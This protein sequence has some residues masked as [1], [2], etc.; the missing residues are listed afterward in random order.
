MIQSFHSSAATFLAA[1]LL[2]FSFVFAADSEAQGS[3]SAGFCALTDEALLAELDGAWNLTQGPG[4]VNAG[5]MQIPSPPHPPVPVTFE[6]DP[7]RGVV[8][9]VAADLSD[10][11][12]MFASVPSIA[13]DLA[14]LAEEGAEPGPP[15]ECP[16]SVVP[17]LIGTN[18]Y[19]LVDDQYSGGH[20]VAHLC[21]AD[22]WRNPEPG[23]YYDSEDARAWFDRN[24]QRE[25]ADGELQMTLY[26]R[27][28]G[29]DAGAGTIF[30]SGEQDGY[31]AM[32][33]AP[34]TLSRR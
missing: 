19:E 9:I 22:R 30:F 29:P 32:A 33:V 25:R 10:N 5:Y 24:C 3:P 6:F 11:M 27:F 16:W 21:S 18:F 2:A 20:S 4:V 23:G 15:T 26:L 17:T 1:L 7:E 14:R 28:S 31:T 34:V 13:E 12:I 8:D